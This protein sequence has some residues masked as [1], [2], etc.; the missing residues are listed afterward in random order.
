MGDILGM[1]RNQCS[2]FECEDVVC[3]GYGEKE[4]LETTDVHGNVWWCVIGGGLEW[5]SDG[6]GSF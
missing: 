3:G 2:E 1:N 6:Y 4:G 5:W